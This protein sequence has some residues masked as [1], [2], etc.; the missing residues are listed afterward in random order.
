M[1]FEDIKCKIQENTILLNEIM[2]LQS[3]NQ[4][5]T[6]T[7]I[8]K[9]QINLKCEDDVLRKKLIELLDNLLPYLCWNGNWL[10]W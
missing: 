9:N 8:I 4:Q 10:V 3:Y 6:Y 2:N 5:I 1:F 7:Y